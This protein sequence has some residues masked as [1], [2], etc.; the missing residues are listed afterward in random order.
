MRNY[1]KKKITK[2]TLSS[3]VILFIIICI[4]AILIS[5]ISS[6]FTFLSSYKNELIIIGIAI[7]SIFIVVK[8]IGNLIKNNENEEDLES[9]IDYETLD[10]DI[11]S[12]CKE[13]EELPKVKS[14]FHIIYN[15][16]IKTKKRNLENK[17]E[18]LKI[19]K[20]EHNKRVDIAKKLKEN[21]TNKQGLDIDIKHSLNKDEQCYIFLQD[22][23]WY[24][25]RKNR[26]EEIL[27]RLHIG[28]LY[29]TNKRFILKTD[30]ETKNIN[31][32]D[33]INISG[34]IDFLQVNKIKGKSVSLGTMDKID[35]F[36][37]CFFY[38]LLRK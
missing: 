3:I 20:E 11:N 23:G 31:W 12:L 13:L 7:L 36:K 9:S 18:K 14:F 28:N 8:L 27:K 10:N 15:H 2:G 26:N 5:V 34:G 16:K 29:I 22:I 6:I 21:L 4:I 30:K 32:N 33:I 37:I 38:T 17:I 1:E 19:L 35:I 25:S 24:E